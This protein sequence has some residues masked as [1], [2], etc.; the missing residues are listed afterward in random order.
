M[1][2]GVPAKLILPWRSRVALWPPLDLLAF[3]KGVGPPF[4]E[5]VLGI[6][7]RQVSSRMS[8]QRGPDWLLIE[9]ID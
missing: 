7:L 2:A 9:L 1:V 8:R 6:H 3:V 5:G 4:A